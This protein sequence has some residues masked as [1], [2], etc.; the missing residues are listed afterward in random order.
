MAKQKTKKKGKSNRKPEVITPQF[1]LTPLHYFMAL[2]AA[3]FA[4]VLYINTIGH[5]YVLDDY[6]AITIN[7]YVQ[8]GFAGIPKLMTVDFWHFSNMQLGYYRPL[9]LITFA[10]EYQV[11]GLS[12]QVSHTVNTLLFALTVFMSFLLVSRLFSTKNLLFP[13]IVSLLFAAHPIH[14]EVIDNLKGR[15]ELLSF[16]NTIVML[17]LAIR[18]MD[19][20]KTS[21]L[22]LALIFFYF[23]LLS[24]ESAMIGVVL[25]PLVL[26]YTQPRSMGKI[27]LNILPFV[28][29]LILFLVQKRLA[30]GPDSTVI[31]T[32][33]VNYPYQGDAVKIPS[34][35]LL[36]LFSIRML[37]F[38]W[39]LRYDYSFNQI[40]AVEW[41]SIWAL[42]GLVVF[43]TL[44]V[45]TVIQIKKRTPPGLILGFF[46]ITMIPLM[47][48][49][50]LRGGIFAER[51]LF[52]PSLAF[53]MA[54]GFLLEKVTKTGMSENPGN[55]LPKMIKNNIPV[56]IPV[57]LVSALYSWQ[58][59]NRNKV[60]TDPLSLF[61]AD[62]KTG[63]NSAQ[64][65]LHYGSELVTLAAAETA[66][67]VK[68]SLVQAGKVAIRRAL[69]IHPRF[70]DAMF[71][72]AYAN[73]VILTYR[74]EPAYVD[75]TI[76]F[77]NRA[78]EY[79][80]RYSEAYRHLG[81][82]YEWM[83]RYDVASYYY[84]RAFE[85]NPQSLEAKQKADE[86]RTTRG[87]D[88]RVNP[89]SNK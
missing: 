7:R 60:W 5:G 6:S 29:V 77:F 49:I 32:D 9:A 56:L 16:L 85:I 10:M 17:Y 15:D 39:P 35:F 50:I 34:T 45:F 79:A 74:P 61:E 70:G 54:V 24:K 82:I 89:L 40:P 72:Y 30:L 25:L 14:T 51:N 57:I 81:I 52:A 78:I 47:A 88:V 21:R 12:P 23:A 84:N 64:N 86:L 26:Y 1:R 3:G 59:Y 18:Y 62:V 8:E 69:H 22:V 66:P 44:L 33:I 37:V 71:R 28:A 38:P 76:Y 73:E 87:L 19:T 36:F 80:P 2:V 41:N 63:E 83:Q 20:R 11:A 48:F 42:M 58:T 31:P 46:Y 4:F 55:S 53:C 27:A 43:I 68:D 65:Q 75:S 67:Q 13:L